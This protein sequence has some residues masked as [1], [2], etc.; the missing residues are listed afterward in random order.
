MK[1]TQLSRLPLASLVT[2]AC[3]AGLFSTSAMAGSAQPALTSASSQAASSRIEATDQLIIRYRKGSTAF[4]RGDLMAMSNAHAIANRAGVQMRLLRRTGADAHV[5]KLDRRVGLDSLQA[6]ARQLQAQ[7]PDIEYV[8]PDRLMKP[9]LVPNDSMYSSQ[10][11]YFEPTGG[12]NLPAA[13][14]A[15]TGTGVV[16]AVIDTGYRPHADLSGRIVGGYDMIADTAT[17]NDG[18]G[19]DSDARDPGD[20]VAAGECGAGEPADTSSWHGTHV[21]G[22]IAAATNNGSGVAGVAFNARVLPIRVLGKCG[23]Y[24][25][26]IADG[27]TWAS[28]GSVPGLPANANP[29][30]VL[31]LSLGGGGAC[32]S[33]TQAAINGARG[34]G[35][36]VVVAAGNSNQNAANFSPASC[37]GVITVAAVNRSGGRAYY[38]NYGSI[39]DVAAPG[40]DT[41][42]SSADGIL[43]TLNAGTGAPAGDNY[44]YYQGTS[45][46]TPHVAGV[47]ALMLSKNPGLTPDQV[48]SLLKSTARAFPATCS[49]CGAGIVNA[50]AAVAAAGDP[51]GGGTT[52]AEVESNNS[53]SAAQVIPSTANPATVNGTLSSSDTDYYAVTL[54]AGKTLTATLTPPS[55]ADYDLYLYNSAGTRIASSTR[56]T[57]LVDTV[58]YKNT[59]TG[60]I[61]VY[62]RAYYYS[63][64]SGGYTLKLS[65]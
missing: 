8:E 13:W 10:W 25:S 9:M 46:A 6:L 58:T 7:D 11:H 22:T 3:L 53:R 12:L 31:N 36:V 55:T 59:G 30:R 57:G 44:A 43:S 42:F 45:M 37:S 21:A 34:R 52:I 24:T 60:S 4:L 64:G 40:G 15:S 48:E 39:V 41:R 62:A 51:G 33:T 19:R 27:I 1:Q 61:T 18:N 16:V 63:G 28:G 47:A 38:S 35:A 65:Q 20:A 23:G 56:S 32:D 14:D 50:A 26:D 5:M 29:A 54:G 49:Q 17:A 2:A